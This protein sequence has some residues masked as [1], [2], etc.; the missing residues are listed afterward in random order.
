MKI[1]SLLCASSLLLVTSV[2]AQDYPT[3]QI[4]LAIPFAAGDRKSVV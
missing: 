1:K 2:A 4:S 3:K